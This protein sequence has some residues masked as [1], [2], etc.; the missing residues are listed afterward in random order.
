MYTHH[1]GNFSL[2][3]LE[4]LDKF[5]FGLPKFFPSNFQAIRI[6]YEYL[7]FIWFSLEIF[8]IALKKNLKES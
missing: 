1:N 4:S 8:F 5:L 7:D 2:H 3:P 6:L